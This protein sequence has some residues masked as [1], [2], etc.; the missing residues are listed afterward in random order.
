MIFNRNIMQ[1]KNLFA[2]GL[3]GSTL[4]AHAQAGTPA[5]RGGR[6]VQKIL[7]IQKY[8]V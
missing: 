1:T 2:L 4:N 5:Q 6:G 3:G 8:P 7:T